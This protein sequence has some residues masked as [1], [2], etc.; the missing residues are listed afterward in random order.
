MAWRKRRTGFDRLIHDLVVGH[1]PTF[2]DRSLAAL[3]HSADHGK[4]WF[5]SAAVLS[6]IGPRERR[7]AVRGVVALGAASFA[8]NVVL[9][10]LVGGPRPDLTTVPYVRR[11]KRTATSGSFPSGHTASAVAFTAAVALEQ[12][13]AGAVLAPV[14][15]AVAYARIH[16]G[17]HWFSD[18]LGGFVVGLSAVAA[19]A[20]ISPPD[21]L[22]QR[23]AGPPGARVDLPALGDGT[24]LIVVANPH[25]GVGVVGRPDPLALVE[26]ELPGAEIWIAAPGDDLAVLFRRA[27]ELGRAIGACGGDGT[28]GLAAGIAT[29]AGKPLLVLPGG[30]FNHFAKAL[31][32]DDMPATLRAVRNGAG[33]A[34]DIATATFGEHPPFTVLNTASLGIY[35]ELVQYRERWQGRLGKPVAGVIAAAKALRTAEPV[36]VHLD[37]GTQPMW[38]AF[39]GVNTY[40]PRTTA[41]VD[42]NRL[43]DGVLDVRVL[44]ARS[45][46]SRF[47]PMWGELLGSVLGGRLRRRHEALGPTGEPFGMGSVPS[48]SVT[49]HPPAGGEVVLAHDGEVSRQG[50]G[51]VTLS[52]AVD[53]RPLRVYRG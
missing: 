31:G 52:I 48:L 53:E 35:P 24:G 26:R 38:T 30:T 50:G 27:A 34:V 15:A 23:L 29:D 51:P 42:R 9:K 1:P 49:I 5:G 11:T 22:R 28:V 19:T 21:R 25:A 3:S 17:A 32:A 16:T 37:G 44:R 7:G 10:R 45:D 20:V 47:R 36:M 33:V 12:P 2:A 41:P 18:V 43:D 14:A 8:A 6:L 40:R 39:V 4:L 46:H 13:V